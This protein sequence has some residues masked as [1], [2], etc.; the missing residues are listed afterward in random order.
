MTDIDPNSFSNLDEVKTNR[1]H[2]DLNCDFEKSNV[3]GVCV[4][5]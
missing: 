1:L 4:C 3:K 5:V 2:L